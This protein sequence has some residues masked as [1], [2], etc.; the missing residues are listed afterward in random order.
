MVS[1]DQYKDMKNCIASGEST[2]MT[3]AG[4]KEGD[5]VKIGKMHD[6][7]VRNQDMRKIQEEKKWNT[8]TARLKPLLGTYDEQMKEVLKTFPENHRKQAQFALLTLTKLPSVTITDNQLLVAGVP[9]KDNLRDIVRDVMRNVSN[10]ED[11]I[12]SLRGRGRYESD[13]DDD[14]ESFSQIMQDLDETA[15]PT[16]GLP[17]PSPAGLPVKYSTP[18]NN[19]SRRRGRSKGNKT[20]AARARSKSRAQAQANLLSPRKTLE[21]LSQE[22]IGRMAKSR[23]LSKIRQQKGK[24][25]GFSGGKWQ[26]Y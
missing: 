11:V 17:R 8:L 9:S 5:D 19:K 25:N 23:A 22:E 12:D 24:G 1:A 2:N 15:V 14:F 6:E 7:H 18:I 4:V 20:T 13:D 21:N 3:G 26:S 10:V 16:E